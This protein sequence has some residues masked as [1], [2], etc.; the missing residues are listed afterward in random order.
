Y[1]SAVSN[2]ERAFATV[3]EMKYQF[4]GGLTLRSV[5]AYQNKRLSAVSE[6]DATS[7]T[8][9]P[10]LSSANNVREREYS[11]EINIISPDNGRFK[12]VV[13]GYAQRN[14]IDLRNWSY[15]SASGFTTLPQPQTSKLLLGAFGQASY[16]LNDHFT[17][18]AGLRY[19]HFNVDGAGAVYRAAAGST[20]SQVLTVPP[21]GATLLVPQT[22]HESDGQTTGKLALNYKPNA[23]NLIYVFAARG[24][25]NGGINPPG[26]TFA[27]ET[28]WDYEAGWKSTLF[29]RHL[30]TQLG[31][32]YNDYKNFQM[33]V[34]NP[35]SGQNGVVNL[36]SAKIKGFEASF[37]AK[38]NALSIDGG[39][40]FVDSS[41]SSFT[42][43]NKW[44]VPSG[45]TVPQCPAGTATTPGTCYNYTYSTS[46]G[47]PNL[48]SPKW[49]WNLSAAYRIEAS[50][51]V[52]VTP[53]VGYAYIGSQWAY[54]T[55][56]A[57]TDLIGAR[58]LVQASVTVDTGPW[59]IEAYGTNLANKFYVAGINGKNELYGA[60]REY[61]V[62]VTNRF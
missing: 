24:Y 7:L 45:V 48:Y 29:N 4:D 12:Y 9:L 58:G 23:D 15:S 19:S 27:P 33:D 52:S 10:A 21:T 37:Q 8:T 39:L 11:Q 36:A 26:G 2:Y 47:G 1:D 44:N 59:R 62:R 46:S 5:T 28:V 22:G 40:S 34:I 13:G 38:F 49:T 57:S 60:P 43:V 16:Q 30:R 61:G 32:F 55:Y 53:R 20:I 31:A 54:P 18:E 25:K 56:Q 17:L 35:L 41:M 51:N 50:E 14:K 3:L 6:T 42:L